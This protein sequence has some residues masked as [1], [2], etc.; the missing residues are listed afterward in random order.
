MT[1]SPRRDPAY[2]YAYPRSATAGE[3][4]SRHESLAA[5]AETGMSEAVAGRLMSVRRQGKAAFADLEDWSGR[6]Q[7]F[8]QAAVLGEDGVEAFSRL[9]AGDI[10]GAEGEVVRTR[11]GELSVKVAK[12]TLLAP[13]LRPMPEKWRGLTDVEARYRQ[14]YL[15][16]MTN[17]QARDVVEAR[18]RANVVMRAFLDERG[19]IEVETPLLQ[20]QAGG[21][22]ARPFVTH[23]NALDVDLYL[24]VA[25]ELYLKR[26]LIGGLEKVY[27][28]NRSFRNEG[29]SA[30]HNPEYTM[31]EAYE[32]YVDYE[33]TMALVEELVK[34]VA[35]AVG[36]GREA[37]EADKIAAPGGFRRI[38]MFEAIAETTG[39][40][41][42]TEWKAQDR[43]ELARVATELGVAVERRWGSGKILL[44]VFEA[45]AEKHLRD[46]TFVVGFPKEVSPLAKDHRTIE[47]FT[48]HAD[49]VVGGVEIAPIY[50]ELN[51]PAEQE[52]RF[53]QQAEARAGGDE[54]AAPADQE[55]LEALR[56]GMPPAGGLGLGVDRLLVVLLG[57]SSIRE[58]I[59]FPTLRPGA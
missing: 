28:L 3:L 34:A 36:K 20:P 57:L 45:K 5:G 41:L 1:Q 26:L 59:L 35:G 19:F 14:R 29:I 18:A 27:E 39:R 58:V 17:A 48:E 53:R 31:L 25:P 9:G 49:L 38:T 22:I 6:I 54:E 52:R 21:A 44:E 15:D 55:F 51:D 37:P 7:L 16:L 13:C 50:S 47:G 30:R 8:A 40:D 43:E 12:W 24:R 32:A 46:P 10:V 4:R 33:H 56:Y 11:R 23:H 42:S 2:P